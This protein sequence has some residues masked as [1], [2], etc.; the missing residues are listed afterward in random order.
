MNDNSIEGKSEIVLCYFDAITRFK[1]HFDN[2]ITSDS[3]Q[4]IV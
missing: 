3:S 4:N 1:L 2:A